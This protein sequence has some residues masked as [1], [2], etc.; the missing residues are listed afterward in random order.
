MGKSESSR[1]HHVAIAS[2]ASFPLFGRAIDRYGAPGTTGGHISVDFI[3]Q[4]VTKVYPDA[5]TNDDHGF[6]LI[7]GQQLAKEDQFIR[8]KLTSESRTVDGRC[9]KIQRSRYILCF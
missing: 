2:V 3:A 9:A 5:I 6:L 7:N 1:G 4:E 8:W